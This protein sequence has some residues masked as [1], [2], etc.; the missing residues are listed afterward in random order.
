MRSRMIWSSKVQLAATPWLALILGSSDLSSVCALAACLRRFWF[1][2]FVGLL[3]VATAQPLLANETGAQLFV[4]CK[5]CHAVA[6]EAEQRIGPPL[7]D[8]I[9]RAAG[10]SA[11]FDYSP[12]MQAAGSNGLI[13]TAKTLDQFLAGP[14]QF[15]PGSLMSFPGLSDSADRKALIA[16]LA[17]VYSADSPIAS[18]RA[19]SPV[20]E[21]VLALVGDLEYGEYLGSECLTCHQADG[22]ARGIP[23][24]VGWPQQQFVRVMRAYRQKTRENPVMQSVASG[25]GDEEIAGLARYFESIK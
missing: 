7:A 22:S 17:S 10:T 13:W 21:S 24:I 4:L 20:P 5:S 14:T 25:L 9:G 16:Y 2:V 12:A 18:L 1:Q 11:S 6:P 15:V 19:D 8:V 23:A 3:L